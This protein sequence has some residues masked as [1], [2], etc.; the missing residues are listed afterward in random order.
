ML[1]SDLLEP[2]PAV[3]VATMSKAERDLL[4]IDTTDRFA[5]FGVVAA[6][7]G[8]DAG[9]WTERH[10]AEVLQKVAARGWCVV[11]GLDVLDAGSFRRCIA[12]LGL[13]LVDDYGDLPMAP[14]DDGTTGVFNVTKYPAKNAILFHH[15][16]S[17]TPAPPRH[18]FFQCT[19]PAEADGETPLADAAA[20]LAEL[21]APIR[22]AFADRGLLYR[23][24]FVD[25]FDVSWQTFFRTEDRAEVEARCARDGVG[26]R[27][28]A[29]GSLEIETPRPAVIRHPDSGREVF[30][31][32][33]LLHHPACLE[34]AV[35]SGLRGLLKGRSLP[36]DV[37]FGDGGVI[38]D[39]WIAEVLRAH[40]RVAACFRWQAG[41][42]V[43][44]DNYAVSHARRT[45]KGPRQHH[46]ILSRP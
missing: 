30:F 42:V 39:E 17:H 26:V 20:L 14:S 3:A 22:A 11:R 40:L 10:R 34:P 1:Q 43:I 19:L 9:D 16:G 12:R 32:Q 46:V 33:V 15:E 28:Q 45:F 24:S 21:P 25:G 13:P 37:F 27:W 7:D 23:R 4:D 36:R 38:P 41:D 29:D 31:N 35:R 18:I 44:A 6:R 8:A 2:A 5:D